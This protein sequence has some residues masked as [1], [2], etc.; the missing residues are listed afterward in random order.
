MLP[1]SAVQR[2]LRPRRLMPHLVSLSPSPLR[3][4][5]LGRLRNNRSHGRCWVEQ[6]PAVS[7]L[8]VSTRRQFTWQTWIGAAWPEGPG[9]APTSCECDQEQPGGR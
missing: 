4:F 7:A 3:K 8:F 2:S 9:W 1:D 5:L 6:V